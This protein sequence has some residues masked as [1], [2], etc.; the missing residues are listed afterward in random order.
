MKTNMETTSPEIINLSHE[1]RQLW[2]HTSEGEVTQFTIKL[3]VHFFREMLIVVLLYKLI[4]CAQDTTISSEV[5]IWH[6]KHKMWNG[7]SKRKV[8]APATPIF[9]CGHSY[10]PAITK[11]NTAYSIIAVIHVHTCE[12]ILWMD[13]L[14]TWH[15]NINQL[16]LLR[17]TI[18]RVRCHHSHSNPEWFSNLKECSKP[19]ENSTN[20]NS[21][22][23]FLP[24]S[25]FWVKDEVRHINTNLP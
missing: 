4:F 25:I 17:T 3:R 1:R 15:M 6:P 11:E 10:L 19:T 20:H 7:V 5:V 18:G 21:M 14:I 2:S 8:I 16:R 9:E 22:T 24:I 23:K 13:S 12:C